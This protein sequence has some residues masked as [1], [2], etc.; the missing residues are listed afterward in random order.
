MND[1]KGFYKKSYHERLKQVAQFADL[2]G[3]QLEVIRHHFD[4]TSSHLIENYLADYGLPEG[5][6]TNFVINGVEHLIPMV[7]EEPSVIAAA[8]NGANM[9]RAGDGIHAK[10]QSRVLTG[11]VVL[12]VDRPA[13]FER[14]VQE[15]RLKL[16]EVARKAHPTVEKYGGVRDLSVTEIDEHYLTIELFVD[17]GDAMGANIINSMLEALSTYLELNVDQSSLMSILSNYGDRN[18]VQASG[19][20]P[21]SALR[22]GELDG[23]MVA[24]KIA[25]ASMIAQKYPKRAATHNKGIMNGIDAVLLATGNDWRAVESAVHAYATRKGQY[26]GLSQ[27]KVTDK[28]LTGTITIPVPSGIIG[29]AT[30]LFIMSRINYQILN[31]NSALQFMEVIAAVGL[32]QNLAALKALVTDGIQRGHMNLQM[33][34]LAMSAGATSYQLDTVVNELKKLPKNQRNLENTQ[35]ILEGKFGSNGRK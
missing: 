19:T 14:W 18:L 25:E 23:Q 34:S 35:R 9:L 28:G 2:D 12:R 17:V 5:I 8:S 15:N 7:I 33:K 20:V 16:M 22:R 3:S 29:G 26:Q 30:H 4:D 6:A 32:A 31:V 1:F 27:W 11:E 10:A 24:K 13:Q 21:F